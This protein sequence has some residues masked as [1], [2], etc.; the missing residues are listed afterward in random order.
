MIGLHLYYPHGQTRSEC[1]QA[2]YLQFSKCILYT[3]TAYGE[4]TKCGISDLTNFEVDK[5]AVIFFS[6]ILKPLFFLSQASEVLL[7]AG[8]I[9]SHCCRHQ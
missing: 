7:L 1:V 5:S 8:Q 3:I 4:A 2:G 6:L 9:Q